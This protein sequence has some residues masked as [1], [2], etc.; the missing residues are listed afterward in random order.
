M[1]IDIEEN[2]RYLAPRFNVHIQEQKIYFH[3]KLS[4]RTE[5]RI[6]SNYPFVIIVYYFGTLLSM[7]ENL[8]II[9]GILKFISDVHHLVQAHTPQAPLS[10]DGRTAVGEGDC[11]QELPHLKH[12]TLGLGG[13]KN[14]ARAWIVPR[15]I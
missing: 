14:S 1:H 10:S 7:E 15:G 5:L 9:K 2:T 13:E 3:R 12:F 6:W 8:Q 4:Q 11:R